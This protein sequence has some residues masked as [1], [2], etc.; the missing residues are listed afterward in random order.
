[1]TATSPAP[2]DFRALVDF[3]CAL[4]S[5]FSADESFTQEG[6]ITWQE[7]LTLL[8]I[9][10]PREGSVA[11]VGLV[12]QW[13][14]IERFAADNLVN[15]LV[16]RRFVERA[17]DPKDRR[18]MLLT[19]TPLGE[20]WLTSVVEEAFPRLAATGALLMQAL[21][22]VMAHAVA[23]TNRPKVQPRIDV[24]TLA[25]RSTGHQAV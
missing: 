13:M 7:C 19:V 12:A 25:W 21:R 8:A 15:D 16:R 9:K 14:G 10:S 3:R 24:G 17:R 22:T 2:N 4:H 5:L 6:N 18:R 23:H 11:T 1:M 20:Q